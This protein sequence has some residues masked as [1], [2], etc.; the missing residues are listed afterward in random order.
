MIPEPKQIETLSAKKDRRAL[1]A[2]AAW[3]EYE[4]DRLAV[5]KNMARLRA[6][7]LAQEAAP[8]ALPPLAKPPRKRAMRAAGTPH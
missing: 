2:K 1:E 3:L 6:L 4:A 5:D 7:R 8:V